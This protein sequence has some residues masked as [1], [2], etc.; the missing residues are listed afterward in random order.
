MKLDSRLFLERLRNR[1]LRVT[2]GM[3]PGTQRLELAIEIFWY[4]ALELRAVDI[5]PLPWVQFT[6]PGHG[7]GQLLAPMRLMIRSE[8]INCGLRQPDGLTGDTLQRLLE[9]AQKEALAGMVQTDAREQFL[10]WLQNRLRSTIVRQPE[11]G[12]PMREAVA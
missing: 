8:L 6:Q 7:M 3:R 2:A 10:T 9:V 11:H 1:M 12:E 4:A 5:A